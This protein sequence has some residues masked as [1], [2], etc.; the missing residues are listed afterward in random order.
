V[1]L[2]HTEGEKNISA[3]I[4]PH[5]TRSD[6]D[7]LKL[8]AFHRNIHDFKELPDVI[9]S[10][11]ALMGLR[12]YG[13]NAFGPSFSEDVLRIK[14]SGPTGLHLSIVD[15]PGLI[16]TAS[17]EQTEEDVQTVHRMVNSYVEKPRTTILAVVQANNDIANQSIIRKSKQYDQAGVRTIGIITKPDLINVSA[18]V[19][20]AA[21]AK[22]QDTTKLKLGFFLLKNP[23]PVEL[24]NGITL[25]QRSA[26]E[27]RFFQ[28][29]PWREQKLDSGRV[30]VGKLRDFCQKLLDQHIE[31]ELPK[32]REEIKALIK[33]TEQELVQLPEER[34]TVGHLRVYLARLAM[35]YHSL[36]ESALNGDY[37]TA[38]STFFA[39]EE[40]E[41][42]ASR[43]R[44]LIHE[45]NTTFREC[46]HLYGE[47]YKLATAFVNIAKSTG[48]STETGDWYGRMMEGM[49]ADDDELPFEDALKEAQTYVTEKELRAWVK[50]VR[51]FLYISRRTTY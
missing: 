20:I 49:E 32:V 31:R 38:N 33:E 5:G 39:S 42:G 25:A 15:L 35:Q 46:M 51:L 30:G 19:R 43:L 13:N 16:S 8:Q 21:L 12:G 3:S 7:K 17:E 34:P 14:Y 2:E 41:T 44:A 45:G 6:P 50:S 10:A 26:N 40:T 9:A 4:I 11:G 27:L 23:T 37:H 48:A 47:T 1:I 28:S 22:N 29:S 18:E 36:A 24:A